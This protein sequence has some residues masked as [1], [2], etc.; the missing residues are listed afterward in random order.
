[1]AY[2]IIFVILFYLGVRLII[3]IEE[4]GNNGGRHDD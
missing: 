4:R 3:F 2:I 1:M